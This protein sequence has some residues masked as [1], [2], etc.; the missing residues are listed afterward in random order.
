MVRYYKVYWNNIQ[1]MREINLKKN[2]W[3]AQ[4]WFQKACGFLWGITK[5][6]NHGGRRWD[7]IWGN[8]FRNILKSLFERNNDN[9]KNNFAGVNSNFEM[10]LLAIESSYLQSLVYHFLANFIV[11]HDFACGRA[12]RRLQA[13]RLKC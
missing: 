13:G 7:T 9:M 5:N 10:R 11:F 2:V 6:G 4:I 3:H 8:F 12:L 1:R